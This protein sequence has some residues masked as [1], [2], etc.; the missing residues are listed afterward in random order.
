M[1]MS[2][3]QSSP[4][5]PATDTNC[6]FFRPLFVANSNGEFQRSGDL[7]RFY[8]YPDLPYLLL[9]L[10]ARAL[11]FVGLRSGRSPRRSG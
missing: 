8:L 5:D 4:F 9:G 10:W 2:V 3:T 7:V 6:E 11:P 1:V